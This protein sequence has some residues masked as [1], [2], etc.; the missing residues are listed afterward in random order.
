M[1]SETDD[2]KRRGVGR[3]QLASLLPWPGAL[4]KHRVRMK[5]KVSSKVFLVLLLVL[6]C[7]GSLQDKPDLSR[8]KLSDRRVDSH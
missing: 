4:D 5:A 3:G 2:N 7:D 8:P 1:S 6:L